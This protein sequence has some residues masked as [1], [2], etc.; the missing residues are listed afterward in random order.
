[1]TLCTQIYFQLK[2][3]NYS[4]YYNNFLL[5]CTRI[6][7]IQRGT[8]PFYFSLV[9]HIN[10]NVLI[11]NPQPFIQVSH[12]QQRVLN[13]LKRTRLSNGTW[14]DWAPRPPSSPSLSPVSKLSLFLNL[15]V[16][17]QSSLALYKSFNNL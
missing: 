7:V 1:M 10:D 11:Q 14:C 15:P 13:G 4:N 8:S 2:L 6:T 3:I 5:G 9:S 12:R 17:R 16:C